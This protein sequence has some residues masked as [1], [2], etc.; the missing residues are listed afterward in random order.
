MSENVENTEFDLLKLLRRL[1]WTGHDAWVANG[2]VHA[3]WLFI[4]LVSCKFSESSYTT[5]I[6]FSIFCSCSSSY[7]IFFFL[8]HTFSL[9]LKLGCTLFTRWNSCTRFSSYVVPLLRSTGRSLNCHMRQY[10]NL[11]NPINV[12]SGRHL[13]IFLHRLCHWLKL[14]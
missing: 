2:H 11:N 6:F 13:K 3:L 5:N 7:H 12:A 14:C 10:S 9:L 1:V 4:N 8:C